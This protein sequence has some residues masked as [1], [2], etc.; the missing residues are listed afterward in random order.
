MEDIDLYKLLQYYAK[1]W[2]IIV[3]MACLGLAAA[4]NTIISQ[5]L[6]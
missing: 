5:R 1:R 2:L 4:F 6:A 3:L